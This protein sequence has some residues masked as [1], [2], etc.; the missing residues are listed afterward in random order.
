MEKRAKKHISQEEAEIA[1]RTLI[2]WI[3]DDPYREGLVDTSKRF[4]KSY[5]ERF[6]GYKID[7]KDILSTTFSET[8]DYKGIITLSNIEIESTCEHHLAP[9]IGKAT[10]S[11]I[12]KDKV[13]GI[14]KLARVVEVFSHRLQLQERLTSQ[15]ANAIN[16]CLEPKGVAVIIKAKHHCICHRGVQHRKTLMTTSTFLG[17]FDTDPELIQKINFK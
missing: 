13:V 12:P 17:K 7:P 9:I 10:V 11:Y 3:G 8:N 14:S 4:L 16:E 15:I 2:A 5:L 1:V 6:K